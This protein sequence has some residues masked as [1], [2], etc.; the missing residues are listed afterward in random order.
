VSEKST[1]SEICPVGADLFAFGKGH[2]LFAKIYEKFRREEE[3]ATKVILN[4]S[5]D[6]R[7]M[8]FR[9]SNCKS[10]IFG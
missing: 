4:S 3:L 2:D 1:K 10:I 7:S 6:K 8:E 9:P 5:S